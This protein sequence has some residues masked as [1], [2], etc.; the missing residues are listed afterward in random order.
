[1]FYANAFTFWAG[2]RNGANK[3]AV[4]ADQFG[5]SKVAGV[6]GQGKFT[7]AAKSGITTISA[8]R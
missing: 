8:N 3:A 2:V 6:V 7:V 1:V 5:G 4:V